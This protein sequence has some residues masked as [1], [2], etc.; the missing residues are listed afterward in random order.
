MHNDAGSGAEALDRLHEAATVDGFEEADGV[1][2]RLA[3]EA[4]VDAV[5]AVAERRTLLRV[6]RAQATKRRPSRLSAVYSPIRATR[7]VAARTRA[8]SAWSMAISC[9]VPLRP[10]PG[11]DAESAPSGRLATTRHGHRRLARADG[12][13]IGWPPNP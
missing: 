13:I 1:A 12:R 4:V 2:A 9:T 8:M 3:V 10:P 6:E 7:S 5:L 11:R